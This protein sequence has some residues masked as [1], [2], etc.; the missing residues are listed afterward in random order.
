MSTSVRVILGL[1]TGVTGTMTVVT[2]VMKGTAY[3]PPAKRISLPV[4]MGSA[5]IKYSSVMGLVTAEMV[6]MSWSTCA[7]SLKPHAPLISS[8]VIMGIVSR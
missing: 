5:F 1:I 2:T 4:R 6:L 7:M 3:I 8:N